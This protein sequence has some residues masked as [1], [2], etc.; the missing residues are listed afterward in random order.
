MNNAQIFI[1]MGPSGVGKTVIG[2]ALLRRFKRLKKIVTYTTRTPRPNEVN[3]VDYHFVSPTEFTQ[4][5]QRGDFIEHATVHGDSYGSAWAD[6]NELQA[7]GISALFIIDIQGA[8]ILKKKLRRAVTIFIEA[9]TLDALRARISRRRSNETLEQ[10][11]R[12]M[13]TARR[14]LA[15]KN[16]ANHLVINRQGHR[17][18]AIQAVAQLIKGHM[19]PRQMRGRTVVLKA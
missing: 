3:N 1:V 8:K 17:Q 18:E 14:E 19:Y 15:Q 5:I 10:I 9:D 12:R 11:E 7:Q 6:L 4:K 16:W 2:H 13:Q